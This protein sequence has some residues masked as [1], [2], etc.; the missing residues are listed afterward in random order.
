[1]NRDAATTGI[2]TYF[3]EL[4]V[5]SCDPG[6]V[7]QYY[8]SAGGTALAADKLPVLLGCQPAARDQFKQA[9]DIYFVAILKC[10]KFRV[11]RSACDSGKGAILVQ[12]LISF[13]NHLGR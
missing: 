7:C 5:W 12:F 11:G 6:L 13:I 10:D 1:M 2:T 4:A 3:W 9:K 8:T